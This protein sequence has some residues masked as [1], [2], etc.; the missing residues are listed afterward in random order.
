M[1]ADRPT[2]EQLFDML[3]GMEDGPAIVPDAAAAVGSLAPTN[4][5]SSLQE[6]LWLVQQLEPSSTAYVIPCHLRLSGRLEAAFL[7]EAICLLWPRHDALRTVFPIVDGQPRRVLLPLDA[8]AV[9]EYDFS[10]AASADGWRQ[11]YLEHHSGPMP[12]DTGP[13]FRAC[14]Y[15]LSPDAHVLLLD[16]HHING[17]GVS[18]EIL[19]TEMFALYAALR[20][21][22]RFALPPSGPTY[23]DFVAVETARRA[24]A[25][26]RQDLDTRIQSLAGAPTRIDFQ[27]DQPLPAKFAYAGGAILQEPADLALYNRAAARGQSAGL[28]PFMMYLAAFGSLLHL[29]TKQ[30]DLLVGVP[31]SQRMNGGFDRTVGFFVNTGIAR[32]D[33]SRRPNLSEIMRRTAKSVRD[34]LRCPDA[35]LEHLARALHNRRAPDRPPLIQAILSYLKADVPLAPAV[36]GLV[37]EP[38]YVLRRSAMFELTLDLLLYEDKAHCGLEFSSDAW[39]ESS[40]RRML[41]HFHLILAA[42]T[43]HPE[44]HLDE[45][46]LLPEAKRPQ[47]ATALQGE[48]LPA[49]AGVVPDLL[50]DYALR[51]PDRPAIISGEVETTHGR[52]QELVSLRR[53]QL[54]ALGL[55]S[56]AVLALAC[57]PGLEWT[58]TALAALAEGIVVLPLDPQMPA[59]RLRYALENS[60]A[61]LLWHD[62]ASA[63][64][65]AKGELPCPLA[66]GSAAPTAAPVSGPARSRPGDLAYL[67]YTSGTTGQPKGVCVSHAAFAA[68]GLSALHAYGLRT[69][70]RALVFT[71]MHFD[72]A[73]EQLFAPLLAG[74]SVLIRDALLWAPDELCRHLA[75]FR[76]TCVDLPPQ[77][78]REL[79]FHLEN[80]PAC[81]PESLRLVLAGGEAMP[82]ALAQ[83]WF[84]GPLRHV[85]LINVY[86]PTEAVVTALCNRL[87][88]DSRIV[89]AGGIVPIGHPLP[90][91]VLR[92]L[93]LEGREVGAGIAG[94]LCLGGAC[95]AEGYQGDAERTAE[96]FRHWFRTPAGG[97]W[98]DAGT[99]GALRL[100]RTGDRVRLG[101]DD[102]IEFLGRLDRQLKI[103]GFRVE[104]GEVEAALV[105]HPAIVQ[106]FVVSHDESAHG[107]QLVAYCVPAA[108]VTPPAADELATWLAQWLPE[109]MVPSAIM[110]VERLPVGTN[111]KIDPAALPKPELHRAPAAAPPSAAPADA[112]EARI[113]AIWA[114]VLGRADVGANDN[115]FDLGGHSLQLVRVHTR[116]RSELGVQL[117]LIDLFA[118]PTVASLAKKLRGE[119]AAPFGRFRRARSGD[120]AVVGMAGR[121]PG[122]ANIDELWANLVAGR[123]SI[124]FFSSEEL[125]AEGV[126]Q[127]LRNR[128]DYVPAHGHMEGAKLFDAGFFG[129]TPKEAELIDPQQRLF[130]EESWHA[131]EHAGCD[132]DR[133]PGD[134][135]VFAGVG[136]N[137]YLLDNLS[138]LLRG[139]RGADA[140]AI[141]LAN[142]KDFIAT[143]VSYK[144]N[145][146]GPGVNINTACSTSLVAIHLAAESLLREECDLALAG[147]V[148]L[149]LP[150][151]SG[152]VFQSG[153]IASPDGH[154]RAFAD[155]AAGTVGGSGVVV[156]VLK[157]LEQALAEGDT[158]HAVIKGSAINNDGADKVGFTAPGVNRQRDVIRAALDRAGLS[159]RGI[160]YV[161][162]HGTGTPMGDPIEVRALTE[163]FASDRPEPESCL[164]G[165]IKSNIGH[166]DTAAGAAGFVKTVLA[167]RHGQI[168]ATLHCSHPSEKIGFGNTPFRIVQKLTP[169]PAGDRRRAG[170]SSFGMGGTNAHLVLEEAP[171]ASSAAGAHRQDVWCLPVSARSVRSLLALARNL[172]Q[173][174]ETHSGTDA[175]D[176]WF[177]LVEGRR[178]HSVR[179]VVLADSRAGAISALRTLGEADLLRTDREGK[180][181][182]SPDRPPEAAFA[183][184]E[185]FAG[186][187]AF[188]QTWLVGALSAAS[189]LLPAGPHH[190]LPL[191]TY[192]FDGEEYWV[193][194]QPD[195]PATLPLAAETAVKLP[196]TDWFYFPS[197]ERVPA[198]RDEFSVGSPLLVIHHGSAV[199]GRW[200]D[201]LRAVGWNFTACLGGAELEN[202]LAPLAARDVWPAH[203]WH[204]AA[205]GHA[206]GGP[207]DYARRLDVLLADL[208][209]L[210]AAARQRPVRLTLFSPHTGGLD[211]PPEPAFAHLDA[212]CAVV[213]HEYGAISACVLRLDPVSVD[214]TTLRLARV[215]SLDAGR[216]LALSGGKLWRQ[217]FARL[218][219]GATEA[220]AARLRPRGV[221]LIA[222][223][224]GGIGLALVRHLAHTYQARLVLLS[225]HEPDNARRA[226]LRE[227]GAAGAEVRTVALDLADAPAVRALVDDTI[228]R[229]GRLD[230]VVH[231]AGVAGGSLVAR[232][233]LDEIE[234]VLHAKVAGTLALADALRGRE[235]EFVLLCSSLTAALGGPG[236]VAYAAANAWMDAFAATQSAREP[237]RWISV[238]WDSWA[239]VGM[240]A[241]ASAGFKP[242]G[243]ERKLL[244]EWTVAPDSFW[245]WGEH[246]IGGVAVLPGT[247]YL[248]LLVQAVGMAGPQALHAVALSEPM[249]YFGETSRLVQV[250]REGDEL[251]LQSDDGKRVREHARARVAAAPVA[252]ALPPIAEIAA[253][254]EVSLGVGEGEAAPGIVIEAGPRW[255]LMANY[256]KGKDEALAWLALPA[257][258]A[259]DLAQHPLHPGL[260]DIALSYY[261]GYVAGGTS[262]LPWRYEKVLVFA[263]LTARLV[264]HIRLRSHSERAL[265]LDVELR[266]E[267]GRLLMQV[268]GYTLLRADPVAA[269]PAAPRRENVLPTNPFALTP[270][271]GVAV[272][273]HA[274]AA[275]EPTV[276]VSTVD[277]RHAERPSP[278]PGDTN[279]PTG[280]ASTAASNRKPR[281]EIAT[282]FRAPQTGA[283]KLMADVW[284]EVLGYEGLGLDDDLF[285]LGADSLTALQASA[286]LKEVVGRE[287]SMDRFFAKATIAHLAGDLPSEPAPA[288]THTA[289]CG[290]SWEEGEL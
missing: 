54:G 156:V 289:A 104:P 206:P 59:A 139:G 201:A 121:F 244:R 153:G 68:H 264:S 8:F 70:D 114:D 151:K 69:D 226:A 27:F 67:I 120:V 9:A 229:W 65:G 192:V 152:Y 154:C 266:D 282:P 128:P 290:G 216:T 273:L 225:R 182:F 100:Y 78:L 46:D 188:A 259:G 82:S 157:R 80:S 253:R 166:L 85:P 237:D 262:V 199:E 190:R 220:G 95:L 73:W 88:P 168:P 30:E 245:P 87:A 15:R 28:S 6:R 130:L 191:P 53:G 103:R 230:G 172:A 50:R 268:E 113:A 246:R 74:G 19:R 51:H 124:R 125:A 267:A 146:R 255:K 32:L 49:P 242:S 55:R 224:L 99:P 5:L 270:T 176:L 62:D 116:L 171:A 105:C 177:T 260:L 249:V 248:E 137:L 72:A 141:S 227:L 159:A 149:H 178:R 283:E 211:A 240:A 41:D 251:I 252:V 140:Y 79:L 14:L 194:P 278:V 109:H 261:I 208:R 161:E 115:F 203:C 97:R 196:L 207:A 16:L 48:T 148:T 81:L 11:H 26:H 71:L 93:D 75:R 112:F 25:A 239:E 102:R 215:A 86:G 143:R 150:P 17:D 21:G 42:L 250:W 281:P 77:Y 228:A 202:A 34:M 163:A 126:P 91:R 158:I 92:I 83:A 147:G 127:N 119:T 108:G 236:Q 210:A 272:F 271:E 274:L 185:T 160:Q 231:A 122:A 200:L 1:P 167:L 280:A 18:L 45:I 256:R 217:T 43:D 29:H 47:I 169:W 23:A 162:A 232:T 52:L 4:A 214:S 265:V 61:A 40:A 135:G 12:L 134:I 107:A 118:H 129:Y 238:Q 110:F 90:G 198:R 76:V 132:P 275:A 106:V 174:L 204:L 66:H 145:L 22:R 234:R 10:A 111:G 184:R 180:V 136:M 164:L 284:G 205:L 33:F 235:P 84:A 213:P 142:D 285:D 288:T 257:E 7:K 243:G 263:P 60:R 276:C 24:T 101:P 13:L 63:P 241:R 189:A 144:L 197:W 175:E 133:F 155:D 98:V 186:A 218:P 187:H 36:E 37:V 58:V 209:R 64:V 212:V 89:T 117:P 277:W 247:G 221:Y 20:E 287:L 181:V 195:Q 254:C 179:V 165:S 57:T 269:S 56:G 96:A 258:L 170:V 233:K 35:P 279:A 123:E 222:G 38:F 94:E 193:E 39:Q 223:G 286:R 183:T 219:A 3:L 44:S 131:L 173:H 2:E 138:A 31:L